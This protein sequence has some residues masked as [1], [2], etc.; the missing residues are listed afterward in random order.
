MD[1]ISPE[2]Y[3]KLVQK[4]QIEVIKKAALLR[5]MTKEAR[6]RLNRVKM[7]KP[8]VAEKVEIALIQA[9]QMGQIKNRL[10]DEQLKEIL[11]EVTQTK[12]FNL[13]ICK[14]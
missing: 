2:D 10:S 14:K 11:E 13:K 7:V 5:Y 6:E 4:Q 1:Q 8:D 9:L 3:Q 12:N